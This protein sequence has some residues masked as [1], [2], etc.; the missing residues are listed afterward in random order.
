MDHLSWDSVRGEFAFDGSWR[1]I[2]I[3]G[4]S[5]SDWDRM[6]D[7]IQVA[8][9]TR[10]YFRDDQLTEMPSNAAQAFPL[11]EECNRLMS[12][13]FS[14]VQANCHFFNVEEIEF[15]IDPREVKGQQQLDGL[16]GFMRCL[17]DALAKEVILA[18]ENSPEIVIFR[19]RPG[20]TKIDYQPFGGFP[21]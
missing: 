10:A 18:V 19:V 15:D 6:L 8:G 3:L 5:I 12:I 2:Y 17:A 11:P 21:P 14:D 16:L 4:T 1:D 20:E 7:A 9:Y 13:W